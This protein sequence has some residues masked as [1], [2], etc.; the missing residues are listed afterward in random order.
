MINKKEYGNECPRCSE[1][2]TWEH[3]IKCRKTINIRKEFIKTLI[4]EML[5]KFSTDIDQDEILSLIEDILK[6]L[7][8]DD[9]DEYETNQGIIGIQYI[10][11][12]YIVKAWTGSNFSQ[13]K[14]HKLNK[15]AVRLCIEHYY[16]CWID[17]NKSFHDEEYQKERIMQWYQK[18]KES[19][20]ESPYPQVKAYVQRNELNIDRTTLNNIVRWIYNVKEMVKKADKRPQNDIRRY[21]T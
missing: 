5:Q 9:S 17:R 14:Y 7:E 4:K 1:D 21:F 15:I 8:S 6:Y 11:R 3:V 19:M 20:R 12:G 16:N 10:F 13:D 18:V 2:E